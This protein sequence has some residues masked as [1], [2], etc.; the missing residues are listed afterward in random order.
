MLEQRHRALCQTAMPRSLTLPVN[1]YNALM[2]IMHT[3]VL[4]YSPLPLRMLHIACFADQRHANKESRWSYPAGMRSFR[5][6]FSVRH[7]WSQRMTRG[8]GV[9]PNLAHLRR[10]ANG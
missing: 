8:V 5:R 6:T 4:M 7:G 2:G 1:M 9:A 3:H 10:V